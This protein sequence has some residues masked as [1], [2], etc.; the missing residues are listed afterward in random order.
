MNNNP[1]M[2]RAAILSL[3]IILNSGISFSQV[4]KGRITTESG[5]PIPYSTVFIQELKQGTTANTKGDMRLSSRK[6][7]TLSLTRVWGT[8]L[9]FTTSGYRKEQ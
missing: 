2:N 9:F 4:L 1:D 6:E 5:D 7:S 3:L 8:L